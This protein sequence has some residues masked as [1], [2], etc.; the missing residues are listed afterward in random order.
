MHPLQPPPA[1][2]AVSAQADPVPAP[3]P[4]ALG[5]EVL[6]RVRQP[7]AIFDAAGRLVRGNAAFLAR[8][9]GAGQEAVGHRLGELWPGDPSALQAAWERAMREQ[10]PTSHEQ[11]DA[12]R[13]VWDEI[14]IHPSGTGATVIVTDVTARRQ[15][16][17]A[18]RRSAEQVRAA[19][20]ESG[21]LLANA[22]Q[23]RE[24]LLSVVEDQKVTELALRA[25]EERYRSLVETSFDWVWEVDA[26]GR[27]TYSSGRV[28][29]ILGYAPE[30]VIGRTPFDFM[31]ADEARRVGAI[32]ARLAAERSKFVE[33]ENVNLHRDGRRVVLETN[34]VPILTPDGALA[35]FRGMDR[36]VTERRAAARTLRMQAAA[37][38]A[39]ANAVMILDPRGCLEWA[40]A[41]F[42]A[43]SGWST[44]EVLGRDPF[45]FQR[46]DS[47]D[48]AFY[49]GIRD[50][51]REG[52][53]WRG[54]I[55]S[56]CKDGSA[57]NE[58]MTITPLRDAEGGITHY[59]A[60]KQDITAHK[61][62]ERRFLHAQRM[63]AVGTLAGGIAHDL[64]NI[65]SPILMIAG[66]LQEK[67]ASEEDRELLALMQSSA[68][69][70][71]EIVRQM[72]TFS[73]AQMIERGP[74]QPRHLIRE[75]VQIVSETFPREIRVA[76]HAPGDL[77]V[78]N[79][80]PTQ[81]HQV[82]LNLCVNARDAMPGGGELSLR[83]TNRLLGSLNPDLPQQAKPG[84][85]VV[86]EIRDTGVGIPPEVRHRIFDPFFTTKAPGKGTGLGLSTVLGIVR[87]HGGFVTVESQPGKG[88]CF[89]VH[90]P[91]DS[92]STGEAAAGPQAPA[93]VPAAAPAQLVLVVDDE[94][95]LRETTRLAL[96][97]GGYRVLTAKDGQEAVT[98]YLQSRAEI[99]AV[100][101][102]LMMPAM[103]GLTLI[104]LLRVM[105]A[106]LRILA[107]TGLSDE[108]DEVE[109]AK[110]GV[111]RVVFKPCS[112]GELLAA[113]QETLA[114][115]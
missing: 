115:R 56:R 81:L 13:G 34:A 71:A 33:L 100:L 93:P 83:A 94:D 113:L 28:R 27:Y 37:L 67:S 114:G 107:T 8:C 75:M 54:E 17:E 97:Q 29:E 79:A 21:V 30:E 92:T 53:V 38:E 61:E 24:V 41:A 42:A 85:Y 108:A 86:I 70:G 49:A 36:D 106:K 60:I 19:R 103:N 14:G 7:V 90:L 69:R 110:L 72:L 95:I 65:L 66:T 32:F 44:A 22:E 39:A 74:L 25:N 59:I 2:P 88:S 3:S 50:A 58:D 82:L 98:L 76:L 104:R 18:E 9:A 10:V 55:V 26:E 102:D 68:R 96:E 112:C 43:L 48:D 1:V 16:E 11:S 87:D 4:D 47:H 6:A 99:A 101:T 77:W 35:G 91:A 20:S 84:P 46:C 80:N 105:D 62:M 31:P 73:R 89:R 109:L 111:P 45:E 23:S 12:A 78:V 5:W 40:N 64:N 57:R 15:A 51:M 63:E 52:Q